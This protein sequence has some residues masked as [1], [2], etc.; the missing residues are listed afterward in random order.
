M[1]TH[2]PALA[3]RVS[4][5]RGT[6]S[7]G[8]SVGEGTHTHTHTHTPCARH[9]HSSYTWLSPIPREPDV[10]ALAACVSAVL[11]ACVWALLRACVCAVQVP[12]RY[13]VDY[14]HKAY[15]RPEL[16]A[17]RDAVNRFINDNCGGGGWLGGGDLTCK[18]PSE[19][20]SSKPNSTQAAVKPDNVPTVRKRHAL[21][22]TQT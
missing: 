11:M 7:L 12:V 2:M 20:P 1:H 9:T 18:L 17:G 19:I 6:G 8:D 13:S 3:H 4:R 22:H 14:R 15:L 21:T 10:R 5:P 16:A